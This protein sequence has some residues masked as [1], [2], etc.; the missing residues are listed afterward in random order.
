MFDK[1]IQGWFSKPSAKYNDFMK[2][3]RMND[4]NYMNRFMNQMTQSVIQLF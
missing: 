4:I 3:L 1:M 2:A